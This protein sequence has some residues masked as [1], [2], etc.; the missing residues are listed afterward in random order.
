MKFI[1]KS[2]DNSLI[3][4]EEIC[5][6]FGI[7]HLAA[8]VLAARGFDID[9]CEEFLYPDEE[10]I[11]SPFEFDAMAEVCERID[12]AIAEGENIAIYSDYDTDGICSAAILYR[13]L[14]LL[15]TTPIMYVPDR[16]TEGY[17]TNPRAITDLCK[18]ASLIITVDCGIKSISDVALAKEM[19]VDVIITDHHE[20]GELPDTPYIINPK[21]D[22]ENYPFKYLCGAGIA[23]KL[24][25][26]LIDDED[27]LSELIQ[28]AAIAT[29]ADMVPLLG[30]NRAIA[31]VGLR[32]INEKPVMG[33][34]AL[35]DAA[36]TNK[37]NIDSYAVGYMLSPR[38]NAAGRMA[39]GRLALNML[40]T[41]DEKC[42]EEC[43]AELCILNQKRQRLQLEVADKCINKI[44]DFNLAKTKII[45]VYGEEFEEGIVG[46]AASTLVEKLNRPAVVFKLKDGLLTGSARSIAGIDIYSILNSCS[47]LYVKFGGHEQAAGLTLKLENFEE[48][49]RRANEYIANTYSNDFFIKKVNYDLEITPEDITL[50]EVEGLSILEPFGEGNESPLFYVDKAVISGVRRIGAENKHAKMRINDCLNMIYFNSPEISEGTVAN[51]SGKLMINEYNSSRTVQFNADNFFRINCHESIEKK[52]QIRG[53]IKEIAALSN[54]LE[55][56][57]KY[58]IYKSIDKWKEALY[59]RNED[60]IGMAVSI[61]NDIG[62]AVYK[63]LNIEGIQMFYADLPDYYSENAVMI[64]VNDADA[65]K[66]YLD[67]FICGHLSAMEYSKNPHILLNSGL[68]KAYKTIAKEKYYVP[69]EEYKRYFSAF[70]AAPMGNTISEILQ[71]IVDESN[72]AFTFEKLWYMLNVFCEQKLIEVKK[73]DK[74]IFKPNLRAEHRSR[75]KYAFEKLLK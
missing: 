59:K 48:L 46:L 7:S 16:F 30:E 17:G 39:S 45:M 27:K 6:S 14:K 36:L 74:I 62:L 70:A 53:F 54:I 64:G 19:G 37:N 9:M 25:Y 5:N 23:Y 13:C 57:D 56:P 35:I 11:L 65:L 2:K 20:C 42:A 15:G 34:K 12:E 44:K 18:E 49:N 1:R 33:I 72:D 63:N 60:P 22:G 3:S 50:E 61:G 10:Q 4:P 40:I 51:I 8:N 43:A 75:T 38:I 21:R 32:H 47:E 58:N 67:V 26:A 71:E 66:N 28:Y 31:S 52:E 69:T 55:N 24:A 29:I 73:S 68:F 41:D